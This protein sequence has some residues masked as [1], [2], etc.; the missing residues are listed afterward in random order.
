M[1]G[2]AQSAQ[3]YDLVIR[4]ARVLDGAGNPW[5][6][7][8]VAVKGGRIAKVGRVESCGAREI[9]ADGR[10]LAPGFIDM[11]DQSGRILSTQGFAPNKLK[12]GVTTC[13]AGELGTP[14][15]CNEIAEWL[16]AM[17]GRI[18]VNFGSYYSA[19]QARREIMGDAAGVPN[20]RELAA[21][22][23][24]VSEAMRQGAFG[25]TTAL[26]YP[27]ASF[28][29][30]DELVELAQAAS[31]LGGIYATHVRDESMGLVDGISEAIEIGE[32]AGIGVEI[33]HFK[34]AWRP[35][36]GD[37]M[38]KAC[39]VIDDARAR[40]VSVAANIYPYVAAA[41]GLDVTIPTWVFKDGIEAA[42][43]RLS[44]P[45]FRQQL[46]AEIEGGPSSTWS[47]FVAASGGW[48]N[49]LLANAYNPTYDSHRFASIAEIGRRLERHPADIAWDILLEAK[50]SRPLAI[51][52]MMDENDVEDAMRRP[53][54]SIGSDAACARTLGQ[55]DDLGLPHPRSYGTFARVLAEYVRRRGILTLEDAVRKMTS[56]PASR[57]G[58]CDRGVIREGLWADFVIFDLDSV[59]D[60]AD[61]DDPT[62]ASKGFDYVAVNGELA[63]DDGA[64]TNATPGHALLGPGF[65]M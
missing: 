55:K 59:Q 62:Q 8:D 9:E 18:S 63:I 45:V 43:A 34:A 39:M 2:S 25:L 3:S 57:M 26:I 5:V 56:W 53:W 49:I 64:L 29:S 40:G 42:R 41:T 16:N 13:I 10:Y 58:L 51:F 12:M 38:S 46:K 37:L 30:T 35:R 44:D 1:L 21:M 19:T 22:K 36:A 47:N 17:S 50:S 6:P 11:M 61:W 7:A 4:G 48:E 65:G 31:A 52:F 54:T 15:P 14:V 32:R 33:F 28:H 60:V 23:S 24:M 27:P 20:A